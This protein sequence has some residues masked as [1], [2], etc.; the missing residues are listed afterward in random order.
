MKQ[1]AIVSFVSI[2][3]MLF[4][5]HT[6]GENLQTEVT[7]TATEII[8]VMEQGEI[9]VEAWTLYARED[10]QKLHSEKEMQ[11][12]VA[13]KKEMLDGFTWTEIKEDDHGFKITA[14]KKKDVSE[15]ITFIM[16][17]QKENFSTYI[18]YEL[19][20]TQWNE[21][22]A[23]NVNDK[24]N[25]RSMQL[26]EE[27]PVIFTCIKGNTGDRMMKNLDGKAKQLL[28]DLDAET[29]ESLTEE[30]FV[31]YSAYSNRFN[32]SIST[33]NTS[34][35]V[36]LALRNEGL[37]GKTTVIIGTPIITIEY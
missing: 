37:G 15:K 5:L 30:Q 27:F 35:N 16:Y 25:V 17:G 13:Q 1:L 2:F 23:G 8:E 14:T 21:K 32:T 19:S 24:I 34:M 26:F 9:E 22:I 28:H 18:I 6:F 3:G 31:S 36:Q 4:S 29:V 11:A 10:G 33:D 20:G 7:Q 12:W